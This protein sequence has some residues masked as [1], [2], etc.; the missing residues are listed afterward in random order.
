ME[1]D[2]DVFIVSC[3][4][5]ADDNMIIM[6]LPAPQK[7]GIYNGI[8]V[9]FEKNTVIPWRFIYFLLLFR[10]IWA[11]RIHI[12]PL[13]KYLDISA[14]THTRTK[15]IQTAHKTDRWTLMNSHNIIIITIYPFEFYIS[16]RIRIHSIMSAPTVNC[17]FVYIK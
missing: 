4:Q 11:T 2:M 1:K 14:R 3:V 7:C 17:T 9:Q 10:F 16:I 8:N 6:T 12:V 5:L 13:S 15:Q